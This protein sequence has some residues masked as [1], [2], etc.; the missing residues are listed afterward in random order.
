ATGRAAS[1]LAIEITKQRAIVEAESRVLGDFLD[2]LLTGNFATEQAL[3]ARA[4]VLGYDIA[5]PYAV[6]VFGLDAVSVG[7]GDM[8][9][10]RHDFIAHVSDAVV[11]QQS[12]ALLS[13]KEDTI[14]V[15]FPTEANGD[16]VAI[17]RN[18]EQIRRQVAGRFEGNSVSAGIGRFYPQVRDLQK[19]YREA[20]RALTIGQKLLGGSRTV[21]FDDLGIFRL[22]F[23]LQ[24]S[25]ELVAF[26][27]ETLSSLVEYDRLH[28]AQLVKTLET[29]FTCHGNLS[30]TAEVLYLHRNTLIYRMDRIAEITG[31]DLDSPEDRL[32]LQVA[33]KIRE[34]QFGQR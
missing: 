34:I 11:R 21:H 8:Q 31:L 24:G 23:L 4:R 5:I 1:V 2:D 30:K 27:D 13:A 3:A 14:T 20:E 28:E 16:H 7:S 9:K 12:H 15:L 26:Y 6:L 17:K 25:P 22:L 18:A 10:L 32:S 19:G 29:Y 33:L